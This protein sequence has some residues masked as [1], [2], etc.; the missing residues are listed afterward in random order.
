MSADIKRWRFEMKKSLVSVLM[1]RSLIVSLL[2]MSLVMMAGCDNSYGPTD[3]EPWVDPSPK[4]TVEE[5]YRGVWR[6]PESV[7]Y[8][9]MQNAYSAFYLDENT[10]YQFHGQENSDE[11]FDV[12]ETENVYTDGTKLYHQRAVGTDIYDFGEF[13]SDTTFRPKDR[14]FYAT[15]DGASYI[16]E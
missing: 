7:T 4:K 14:T 12:S 16:K 8:N 3:E 15:G 2:S 11:K 10:F 9:G 6:T 1:I 13:I 5:K